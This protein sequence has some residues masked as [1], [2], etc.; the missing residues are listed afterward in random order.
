MIYQKIIETSPSYIKAY[1]HKA[2]LLMNMG[3]YQEAGVVF[4]KV[5]KLNPE[6]YRAY[7]GIGI[8]FDKLGCVIDAVRYYKKF[9]DRRPNSHHAPFVKTRLAELKRNK[10]KT[11]VL[12]L[13]K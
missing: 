12:T 13:V 9:L 1:N 5:L 6:Y 10:E 3:N 11:N 4:N 7:L 8:C 2:T